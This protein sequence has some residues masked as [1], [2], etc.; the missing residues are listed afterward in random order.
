[1]HTKILFANDFAVAVA[2]VVCRK[3]KVSAIKSIRRDEIQMHFSVENHLNVISVSEAKAN[4]NLN[5]KKKTTGKQI[6]N[7]I[8]NAAAVDC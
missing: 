2:V 3:Q 8:E 4:V 7:E 5:R 1:M 6:K